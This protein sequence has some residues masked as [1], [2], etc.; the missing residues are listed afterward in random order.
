MNKIFE[1]Y[2]EF[3]NDPQYVYTIAQ[4]HW[5]VILQKNDDTITNE[6]R[7][8][9]LDK[10]YATNKGNYF[11]VKKIFNKITGETTN[12]IDG[13]THHDTIFYTVD[14]MV[15]TELTFII[16][17]YNVIQRAYFLYDIPL[18]TGTRIYWHNNGLFMAYV[19]YVDGIKNGTYMRWY[20][21]G[22][23]YMEGQYTNGIKTG[24]WKSYYL[25]G[26]MSS[27]GSFSDGIRTGEWEQWNNEGNEKIKN[28]YKEF[29]DENNVY[30]SF[31]LNEW[32]VI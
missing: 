8:G 15:S 1:T 9:V 13:S 12:C 10:T 16:T 11:I 21:N 26:Q 19:D 6:N 18:F 23:I 4:K 14:K 24:D 29:R 7:D 28:K 5:I 32:L 27:R 2:S 22:N 3:I 20:I 25:N 17:Y 30:N 31:Q